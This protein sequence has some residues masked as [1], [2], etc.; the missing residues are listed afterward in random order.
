MQS[1]IKYTFVHQLMSQ[2]GFS[3][4]VSVRIVNSTYFNLLYF[5]SNYTSGLS[6]T[7]LF[8]IGTLAV[9]VRLFGVGIN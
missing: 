1:K 3:V 7:I 6:R 5:I 8:V 2:S 9:G 4:T